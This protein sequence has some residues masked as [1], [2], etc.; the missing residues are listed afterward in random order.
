[1]AGYCRRF[2]RDFSEI[3]VPLTRLTKKS[4]AFRWG[5]GQ[6][7]AFE[8]LRQRLYEAPILTLPE[9]VDDFVVY[10]D[11]LIKGMGTV[12][13]QW[14]HVIAGFGNQVRVPVRTRVQ[15]RVR[16][17]VCSTRL[18]KCCKTTR[19]AVAFTSGQLAWKVL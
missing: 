17:S 6:Q 5:P 11:A 9:G 7:A 12:L 2:I 1:M 3:E 16:L 10:G 14:G 4:V 8:A 18:G 13:I 15:L 19:V